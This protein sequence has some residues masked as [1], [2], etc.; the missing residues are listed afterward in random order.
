MSEFDR[1]Y[2][3]Y[4]YFRE[5]GGALTN[6]KRSAFIIRLMDIAR[7][8]DLESWKLIKGHLCD[9]LLGNLDG[10]NYELFWDKEVLY[11]ELLD[12]S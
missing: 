4:C 6:P 12:R 11:T 9:T 7:L 5:G 10:G 8:L 1:E 3:H 2:I